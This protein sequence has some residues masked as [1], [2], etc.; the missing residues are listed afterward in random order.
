MLLEADLRLP[1]WPSP[2]SSSKYHKKC[3]I[4]TFEAVRQL[5]ELHS[6]GLQGLAQ[7]LG[8]CLVEGGAECTAEESGKK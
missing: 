8:A 3:G 2:G 4:F 6:L 5:S 7:L 1:T